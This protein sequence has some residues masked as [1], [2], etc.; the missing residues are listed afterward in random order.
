M[1]ILLLL[2]AAYQ[3]F[4]QKADTAAEPD[5]T[6]WLQYAGLVILLSI[7]ASFKAAGPA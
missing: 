1:L 2:G 7:I 5:N 3:V 4:F 6:G